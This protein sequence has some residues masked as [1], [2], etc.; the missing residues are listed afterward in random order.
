M[1][2]EEREER[3]AAIQGTGKEIRD[4]EAEG[5]VGADEGMGDGSNRG[6]KRLSKP[7]AKTAKG[8]QARIAKTIK[9]LRRGAISRARQ[10]LE[11][12]GIGD[13][14]NAEIWA[15]MQKNTRR[16]RSP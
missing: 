12:K 16:E 5:H 14:E 10:A 1:R 3:D 6:G 15:Q 7:G 2:H 9:L 11:S 8:D 13:L 4:V